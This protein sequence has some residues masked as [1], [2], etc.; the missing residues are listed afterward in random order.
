MIAAGASWLFFAGLILAA[1]GLLGRFHLGVAL[2]E[3]ELHDAEDP[4]PAEESSAPGGP[5]G[6]GLS[7]IL[8]RIGALLLVAGIAAIFLRQ[9]IQFRDPFV[10]W[11]EDANLLLNGTEWGTTWVRGA[12]G[13]VILMAAALSGRFLPRAAWVVAAVCIGMLMAFPAFTG[14]ASTGEPRWLSLGA[15]T[16]HVLGATLWIGGLTFLISAVWSAPRSSR[17]LTLMAVVP[18]FSPLAVVAVGMLM[19]TGVYASWIH[20]ESVSS[21]WAT[22]YGRVLSAKVLLVGVVMLL[23]A[24]NWKRLTPQLGT[25]AGNAGMVRAA[26]IELTLAH[27]VLVVTAFLIQ[28]TPG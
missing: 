24:I 21:L 17:G 7:L 5:P 6:F 13:T 22:T 19:V 12:V 20:L 8:L 18:R 27:L 4:G 9:L 11:Q 2:P 23:G 3:L 14:H 28:T 25:D 15:D 1:A 10:P 26:S 16:L